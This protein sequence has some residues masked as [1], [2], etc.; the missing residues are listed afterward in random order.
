MSAISR[1]DPEEIAAKLFAILSEREHDIIVKRYGLTG[2]DKVT[3]EEIG[4][5][6]SVT[7]ERVRQVENSSLNK[8]RSEFGSSILRDLEYLIRNILE[9]HGDLMREERLIRTLLAQEGDNVTNNALVRFLLNQLL[10]DRLQSLEESDSVYK[11][12]SLPGISLDNFHTIIGHLVTVVEQHNEPVTLDNLLDKA[13]DRVVLGNTGRD[14]ETII[15]NY[16]DVTKKIEENRFNEWGLAHW[17]SIRPRRMNDKIYLIMKKEGKPLHFVEIAKK[18]N[19]ANFDKRVAYP[20]T[21]HNELI[22]DPK[23]VLVGR[24]IYAL[25]EWG[26]KPGVVLDVIKEIL[27]ESGKPLTRDEIIDQVLKNRMVKR[28]TVML[29]LMNKKHFTKNPDGTYVLAG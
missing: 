17:S 15:V 3:L 24:G 22:L 14:Y 9:D 18:I 2:K 25:R 28:S 1:F 4:T 21:I 16:L 8:I 12:W 11:A 27:K 10:T 19:D 6:Y 26:Y 5:A 13:R 29:A 20:A 23:Y 7:R